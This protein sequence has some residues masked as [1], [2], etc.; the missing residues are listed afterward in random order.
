MSDAPLRFLR[1]PE[2]VRRTGMSRSTIHRRIRD[3]SFPAGT[4]LT[5]QMTVWPE[6][7]VVAWQR[8]QLGDDILALLG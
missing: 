8:E 3:K 4:R 7:L 6:P 5:K 1:M 2:L